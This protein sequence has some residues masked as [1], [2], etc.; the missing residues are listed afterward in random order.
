MPESIAESLQARIEERLRYY[1]DL[2][3]RL[4]FRDRAAGSTAIAAPA[5]SRASRAITQEES[6]L[7]KP[8]SKVAVPVYA[9]PAPRVAPDPP[10]VRSTHRAAG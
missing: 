6:S 1:E 3:I 10:V 2:G 7:P 9:E 8:K 5:I 4:F